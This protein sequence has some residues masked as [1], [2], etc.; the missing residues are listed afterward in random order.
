MPDFNNRRESEFSIVNTMTDEQLRQILREDVNNTEGEETDIE[1]ILYVMEVLSKRREE[2]NEGRDPEKALDSFKQNYDPNEDAASALEKPKVIQQSG[3]NNKKRWRRRLIAA[4]AVLAL[5]VGTTVTA[6]AFR[7]D[8]WETIAKW[9]HETFHLGSGAQ[10]DPTEPSENIALPYASLQEMLDKYEIKQK[11][12]PTWVPEGYEMFDV[13]MMESPKQR[14]F[15]VAHKCADKMLKVQIKDYMDEAPEQI[16]Q[17]EALIE[18]YESEGMDYYIFNNQGQLQAV[19]LSDN[20]E[21]YIS[22]P[23]SIEEI[24]KMIDSIEKG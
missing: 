5:I 7:L 3:K 10:T 24:K 16:E 1:L 20:Y 15:I 12:V 22:G 23:L 11:L 2:R 17:S 14:Q 9:T 8:I 6:G 18:V 19:W 13:R 21:C 4:A